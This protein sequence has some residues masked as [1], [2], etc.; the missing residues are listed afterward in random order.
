MEDSDDDLG[1]ELSNEDFVNAENPLY[2]RISIGGTTIKDKKWPK[3]NDTV[4][5]PFTFPS[6]ATKQDKADIA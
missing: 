4:I 6:S 1:G 5:I 2:A 3:I